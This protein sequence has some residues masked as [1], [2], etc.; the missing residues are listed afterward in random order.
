MIKG[1]KICEATELRRAI[2]YYWKGCVLVV[3]MPGLMEGCH[4]EKSN[5]SDGG[6]SYLG[7][8]LG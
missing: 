7:I 4:E 3:A 5:M 1:L 6:E 8:F 2:S